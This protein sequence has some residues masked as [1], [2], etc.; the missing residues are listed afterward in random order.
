MVRNGS[1]SEKPSLISGMQMEV[2]P[3]GLYFPGA[4]CLP[5][6][7]TGAAL[8]EQ[9]AMPIAS[10][11]LGVWTGVWVVLQYGERVLAAAGIGYAAA[12]GLAA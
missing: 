8:E 1:L 3:T 2:R 11:R 6:R 10:F 4:S 12:E 7:K 9:R 5:F